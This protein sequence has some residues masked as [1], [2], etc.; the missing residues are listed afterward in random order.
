MTRSRA[1]PWRIDKAGVI[2]RVRVTPKAA[3]DG[4]DGMCETPA[5]MALKVRVRAP[6]D[7]GAANA[8]VEKLVAHWLGVPRTHIAI[9]AGGNSRVKTLRI[10]GDIGAVSTLLAQRAGE[11]NTGKGA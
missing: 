5:G 2:L 10:G 9:E 6:A 4:I 1:G 8:A 7:K 11:W 3:G